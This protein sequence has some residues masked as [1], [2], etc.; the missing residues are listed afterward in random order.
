M[1]KNFSNQPPATLYIWVRLITATVGLGPWFGQHFRQLKTLGTHISN[2]T[3]VHSTTG[4]IYKLVAAATATQSMFLPHRS[5]LLSCDHVI[6]SALY[7]ITIANIFK[8]DNYF[9]GAVISTW[10]GQSP[11]RMISSKTH[12]IMFTTPS[13]HRLIWSR[14]LSEGEEVL[15]FLADN[16]HTLMSRTSI[17]REGES[18]F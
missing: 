5:V 14:P 15:F 3:A 8:P 13:H 12:E 1:A 18:I 17:G 6:Q 10:S 16:R 9:S 4:Q 2:E 7:P 11:H